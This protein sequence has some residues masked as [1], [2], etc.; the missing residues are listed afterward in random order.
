MGDKKLK[1]QH[2]Y[3]INIIT[4]KTDTTEEHFQ[5]DKHDQLTILIQ[6][7]T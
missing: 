6:P 1:I 2:Q 3:T 5:N 4:A 7:K